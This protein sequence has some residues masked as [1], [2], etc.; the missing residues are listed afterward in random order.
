MKA[1]QMQHLKEYPRDTFRC[2]KT[3]RIPTHPKT[4]KQLTRDLKT[5]PKNS[6]YSSCFVRLTAFKTYASGVHPT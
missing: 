2:L 6:N 3:V 5:T 4:Q 1:R